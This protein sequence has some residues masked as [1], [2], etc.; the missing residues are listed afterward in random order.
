M[1]QRCVYIPVVKSP[2]SFT[3]HSGTDFQHPWLF[4][5]CQHSLQCKLHAVGRITQHT[6]SAWS[7]AKNICRSCCHKPGVLPMFTVSHTYGMCQCN[8]KCS[9]KVVSQ[10][11]CSTLERIESHHDK[12]S[13]TQHM[14]Q[15]MTV[16]TD[17]STLDDSDHDMSVHM[18][19]FHTQ[20][21]DPK[22]RLLPQ[23]SQ[24]K[25]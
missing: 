24:H 15:T 5:T 9:I 7:Q 20:L 6:G 21:S 14:C 22:L 23:E 8:I 25:P 18:T 3:E 2:L 16:L 12:P 10:S 4:Q 19:A 13:S 17:T 11:C 1:Y